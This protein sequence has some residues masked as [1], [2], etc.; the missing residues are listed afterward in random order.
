MTTEQTNNIKT[1]VNSFRK[2]GI[3][4]QNLQAGILA[5]ISKES[6]FIPKSENLDYTAADIKRVWPNTPSA[7][8]PGITHNPAALGDYKYGGKG[9]NSA[10][11]GYTYRGRGFNQITFKDEYKKFGDLIGV[12]LVSN[13]DKLNDPQVAAD[14]AAAFF[15][16]E[17]K[18]GAKKGSFEKFGVTDP[19]TV[20]DT[21]TATKIA[22]QINAGL[23]TNFNNGVVQEGYDKAKSVVDSL[24]ASL[25]AE[26]AAGLA[27]ATAISA[28]A[29]KKI[30]R[31]PLP[32][33]LVSLGIMGLI[34]GLIIKK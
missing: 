7:D 13:P 3:T 32:A 2:F 24:F 9:G 6:N 27:T 29:I 14:A 25:G 15:S 4:N 33:I 18:D 11:E 1:L 30:K 21:L 5:T 20:N 31:H 19:N 22:V 28:T 26:G 16:Q 23:G 34:V 10:T 17:L 12:D 8:I